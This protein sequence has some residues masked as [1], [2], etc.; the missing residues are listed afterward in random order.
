MHPRPLSLFVLS[1]L[2]APLSAQQV[3]RPE[4]GPVFRLSVTLAQVDA[5][6][7]DR[8]G[9]HVTTLGPADFQ[10]F[11]DGRLQP[12][13]AVAYIRADERYLDQ[14]GVPEPIAVPT[15][16]RDARRVIGLV[17]DDSRMT[18]ESHYR[19]RMALRRFV[20]EQLLPDDL[21][22]IVT[23]SGGR[24]TRWP[25]TFSRAELRAAV[26]R[27]QFSLWNASAA[28]ALEPLENRFDLLVD[29]SERFREEHFAL[30]A[31]NRVAEVITAVRELPGRK[32]VLLVSE[33]FSITGLSDT[34]VRDAMNRLVD[35][36]NRSGV[37]IYAV[38]PRGLVFTGLTAADSGGS[39]AAMAS[40]MS[41]RNQALL[42][43]QD[44]LR[45]VAAQTGGFA[46]VNSNDIPGAFR[47]VM[48]DQRGYY[49]IGFQPASDTFGP[50][51]RFRRV[52]VKV[53]GKGLKVRT[54]AGFYA[55]A[56]EQ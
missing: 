25:F 26:S 17:V 24:G 38:D 39:G 6:V 40:I 36:A 34:F 21:V 49:L 41:R 53:V 45:Y 54:R 28:G 14:D 30:N 10:V 46:V 7:T 35:R 2:C 9:R 37:V 33:G 29:M 1:L 42:E 48:D 22:S 27:L 5:V 44:G 47:R 50:E 56:T 18:F 31:L 13:T 32:T 3:E 12:V 52:K 16:P 11:Q 23:T 19:T 15:R 55:V 43:T 51:R 20:D 8:K 4:P